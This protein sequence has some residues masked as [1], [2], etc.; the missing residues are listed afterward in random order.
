M[1]TV[2]N[3]HAYFL[4]GLALTHDKMTSIAHACKTHY[5]NLHAYFLIGLALAH[6]K[7]TSI[8]HAC[9]THDHKKK[10]GVCLYLEIVHLWSSRTCLHTKCFGF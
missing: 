8:A 3:L 9:K 6:D 10:K 7:M 4:I 1:P 5:H 2:L